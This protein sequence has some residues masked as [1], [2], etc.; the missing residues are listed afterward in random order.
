MNQEIH[1][2]GL[3]V[4]A[5]PDAVPTLR[6]AISLIP[7]AQVHAAAADGRMVV[8]LETDSTKRT[9]DQMDALRALPGVL[10]VALVYQHA[11]QA[12]AMDEEV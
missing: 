6:S 10:S 11:E 2:A 12:A 5:S 1:I 3:V 9:L 4:H 8:T 7:G